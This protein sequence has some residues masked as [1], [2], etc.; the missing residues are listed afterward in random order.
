M[1]IQNLC[2]RRQL[3]DAGD[4]PG[5]QLQVPLQDFSCQGLFALAVPKYSIQI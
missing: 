3:A 1:V 5:D 4:D 2:W